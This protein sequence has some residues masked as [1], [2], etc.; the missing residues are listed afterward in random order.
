MKP[1]ITLLSIICLLTAC[2][3]SG[4]NGP[5]SADLTGYSISD[6]SNSALQKAMK[7]GAN[8]NILE[9]GEVLNGQKSG[10][11]VSY[12]EDEKIKSITNYVGGVPSGIHIA[13][14]ERGQL[15]EQAFYDNGVLHGKKTTYQSGS[16][17]DQEWNYKMGKMEGVYKQFNK[18][19]KLQKEINYKEDVYHGLYRFYNE[20]GQVTLEYE[21]NMGEK[22]RGGIV[23]PTA[24]TD[25]E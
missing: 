7:G 6:F 10:T 2:N 13:M 16:R 8:G 20:E 1:T 23:E 17:I 12:Y 21:Y 9:E 11:W 24:K 22:I 14:N 19:G 3:N 4:S 15:T 5:L 18:S 25:G